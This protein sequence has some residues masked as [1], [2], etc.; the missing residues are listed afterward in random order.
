MCL[1]AVGVDN[2]ATSTV[3]NIIAADK[4]SVAQASD[5]SKPVIIRYRDGFETLPDIRLTRGG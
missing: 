2:R 5:A 3:A 4:W 1:Q